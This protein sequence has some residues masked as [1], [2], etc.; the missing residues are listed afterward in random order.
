MP[1]PM[2]LGMLFYLLFSSMHCKQAP[3]VPVSLAAQLVVNHAWS[4]I[5]WPLSDLALQTE[6]AESKLVLP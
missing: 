6:E 2:S 1:S 3:G 4:T 5:A